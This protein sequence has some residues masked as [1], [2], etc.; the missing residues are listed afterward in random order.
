M[1][2]LTLPQGNISWQFGEKAELSLPSSQRIEQARKEDFPGND[3]HPRVNRLEERGRDTAD[4]S[5]IT[6]KKSDI[7]RNRHIEPRQ[8]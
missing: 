8:F 5:D 4:G 3:R 6:N 1:R 2:R 7:D